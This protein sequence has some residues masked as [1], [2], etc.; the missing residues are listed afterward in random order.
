MSFEARSS[1]NKDPNHMEIPCLLLSVESVGAPF[2]GAD[3]KGS[4]WHRVLTYRGMDASI[5]V[6]S[7]PKLTCVQRKSSISYFLLLLQVLI[8]SGYFWFFDCHELGIHDCI[9]DKRE[10]SQAVREAGGAQ[11]R[12]ILFVTLSHTWEY[13]HSKLSRCFLICIIP[14][15]PSCSSSW[16]SLFFLQS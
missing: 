1:C 12:F 14:C 4:T 13:F 7:L 11:M 5:N 15:H 8:I 3:W 2:L 16:S 9:L 6:Y 10:L